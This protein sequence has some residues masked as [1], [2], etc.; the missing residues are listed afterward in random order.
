M[1]RAVLLLLLTLPWASVAADNGPAAL[2]E[3]TSSRDSEHLEISSLSAGIAPSYITQDRL[4]GVLVRGLRFAQPDWSQSG[5]QV[6]FVDRRKD[7]A[8]WQQL[9]IGATQLGRSSVAGAFTR[10]WFDDTGRSA[11]LFVERSRV[12]SKAAIEKN[13]SATLAG[14]A[15]DVPLGEHV[16]ASGYVAAQYLED[17]N[18]RSHVRLRLSVEFNPAP[19]AAQLQVRMRSIRASHPFTG[20]YYNPKAFEE[21]LV[22]TYF[23]I[24]HRDWRFT[25]WAGA[26]PQRADAATQSAYVAE[27]RV[28]APRM[29]EVP[30]HASLAFGVRRDGARESGYAYRYIM[31][32]LGYRY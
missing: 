23:R 18:W 9:E 12:E 21:V 14:V 2:A 10:G 26:G 3:F 4:T 7:R 20:N 17:Q 15:A 16:M 30:L 32:N 8:G 31:A 24:D 29:A 6:M 19:A 27:A 25:L 1:N 22:G 13:I 11:E 5:Q 28:I